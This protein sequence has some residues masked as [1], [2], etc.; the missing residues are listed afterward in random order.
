MEQ[1]NSW[2]FVA[3]YFPNY[4]SSQRI[5]DNDDLCKLNDGEYEDGDG[6]HGMLIEEF[7]NDINNPKIKTEFIE[8]K[9]LCYEIAIQS[10]LELQ[11]KDCTQTP[12]KK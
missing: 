11:K 5:A 4:Y 9:M 7:D 3:E 1:P 10:F 12:I 8:S 6:A 2:D